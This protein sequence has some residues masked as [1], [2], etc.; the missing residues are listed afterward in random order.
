MEWYDHLFVWAFNYSHKPAASSSNAPKSGS[1]VSHNIAQRKSR[2]ESSTSIEG[3][4]N[5]TRPPQPVAEHGN[6]GEGSTTTEEQ[7]VEAEVKPSIKCHKEAQKIIQ[8]LMRD[9]VR[10]WYSD[11]TNDSEFLEDVQK[12]LEHIALEINIRVQQMDMEKVSVDLLELISPYLEVLNKVG[13]RSFNGGLEL[14]DVINDKCLKEF[15][16]NPRVAHPA[17]RSPASERRHYRQALDAILQTAF[18]AEYARCDVASLF[19]RELLLKNLIE[20]VFD[21][22]CEPAFL[23][24]C[25][26]LIL[27]KASPEKVNQQLQEIV[28]EN[29]ELDHVLNRGRLIVN[30]MGAHGRNSRRFHSNSGHFGQSASHVTLRTSRRNRD[31]VRP[32]SFANFSGLQ[33]T[34]S[35]IY[36]SGTWHT[37]S[38]KV[39]SSPLLY[40][41]DEDDEHEATYPPS[42]SVS[43]LRTSPTRASREPG[44][45]GRWAGSSG[46]NEDWEEFYG[47]DEVDEDVVGE[48]EAGAGGD[49]SFEVVGGEFAVVQ[50]APIYIERHVRVV[51]ESGSHHIAYIFKVSNTTC[52]NMFRWAWRCG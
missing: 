9:F 37:Q 6:D 24:E 49:N 33:K 44:Q 38:T 36:E 50:L 39:T 40:S 11:I 41:Q 15:E 13:S 14:F 48:M 46:Y 1:S 2:T 7:P 47:V 22:L 31:A 32:H 35:G 8:L 52:I 26:P 23:Y 25:I 43:S 45:V 34:S 30:I 28:R 20:P 18:P 12:V 29:E 17:L 10:S 19:V 4:V 27:L 16:A 51:R 21:L 3:L 42:V 5:C